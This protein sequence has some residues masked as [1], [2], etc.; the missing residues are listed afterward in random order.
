MYRILISK[1]NMPKDNWKFYE[2]TVSTIDPETG[3]VTKTTSVYET[4]TLAELAET[5]TTLLETCTSA[6]VLPV[7]MLKVDLGVTITDETTD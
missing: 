5:Y 2:Q 7:D 1:P 3:E 6:S 4:D